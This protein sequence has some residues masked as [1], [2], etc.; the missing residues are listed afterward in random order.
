MRQPLATFAPLLVAMLQLS[1]APARAVAQRTAAHAA[2]DS[3]LP[4]Y[5]RDRGT[6]VPTSQFGTYVR[7]G[8]LL[9][10]PFAEWYVDRD[11]E[12]KPTELGYGLERD[13]RGHYEA[14]EA[15]LFVSYGLTRNIAI[16]LEG[17]VIRAAL[18]KSPADPS[19]MPAEVEESGLGDVEGQIRW[20]W[21]EESPRR[22]EAFSFFETVFPLQKQ[23]RLIGTPDWE[24]ALGTG[25]TRGYRWGTMTLR[26]GVEYSRSE[27]KIDAGEY[28]IEHLKRWSPRLRTVTV[29]EGTQ[30]DEV[31]L[32]TEVQWHLSRHAFLKANNGWGLTR[33]A[34]TYAPE[35]GVMLVF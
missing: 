1:A 11:L 28:A 21:M 15:L 30:L 5:L 12:Y 29:I 14:S 32:I 34:T 18:D 8:E 23:R 10:Y 22:P 35:F 25:V 3:S 26:A 19:A 7:K 9:L 16:E 13:F 17:A 24:F 20:R 33:N 4:T 27:G 31:S 2:A 6:G